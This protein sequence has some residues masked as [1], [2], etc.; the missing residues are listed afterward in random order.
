MRRALHRPLR[1]VVFCLFSFGTGQAQAPPASLPTEVDSAAYATGLETEGRAPSSA[2]APGGDHVGFALGF[3]GDVD[4]DGT[5]DLLIG[6]Y[7][8]DSVAGDAG[9]LFVIAGGRGD[10]L[11]AL[12]GRN[13]RDNFGAAIAPTGDVD[14]DGHPDFAVG[15][16]GVDGMSPDERDK[17]C[18]YFCSGQDGRVIDSV[19]GTGPGSRLGYVLANAGDL[20]GDGVPD[21]AVAQRR[22]GDSAHGGVATV[23]VLAGGTRAR[24][25]ELV[26][27]GAHDAFGSAIAGGGDID[28]DGRPD[29]I[30]GAYR[31]SPTLLSAGAVFIYSGADGELTARVD[32]R[33]LLAHFGYSVAGL[34]D[35]DGDRRGEYV[36]GSRF[37]DEEGG[38]AGSVIILSGPTGRVLR[39]QA[40]RSGSLFGSSVAALGDLDLDRRYELAVGAPRGGENGGGAVYVFAGSDGK[41]MSTLAGEAA[42][43]HFGIRVA[44]GGDGDG[45]GVPDVLVGAVGNDEGGV[46]AGKVYLFSGRTFSLLQTFAG[47]SRITAQDT[48]RV[49]RVVEAERAIK[50]AADTVTLPE[51]V[52]DSTQVD[53]MPILRRTVNAEYPREA[54]GSG[55]AGWVQVRVL[56]LADGAPGRVDIVD[57][58][59]LGPD[60]RLAAL[61]AARQWFFLPATR[62]G[63]PVPAWAVFPIGFAPEERRE[64]PTAD[65]AAGGEVQPDSAGRTHEARP[66]ASSTAMADA[67]AAGPRADAT[68]P[69]VPGP[70]DTLGAKI[71]PAEAPDSDT[72]SAPVSPLSTVDSTARNTQAED[73]PPAAGDAV[74]GPAA[75]QLEVDPARIYEVS[76]LDS[77]PELAAKVAPQYP[78]AAL[79]AG[80]TGTV[81]VAATVDTL[82]AVIR[83]DAVSCTVPGKGFEESAKAAV[84]R[85]RFGP[86]LRGGRKATF[87]V[88]YPVEFRLQ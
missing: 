39:K 43:D 34:G 84:R 81:V 5:D 22:S 36:V 49:A 11:A 73:V 70:T 28:G 21:L 12:F 79:L 72:N 13:E 9:A 42:G 80:D 50:V 27:P 74:T 46:D 37:D 41:L 33:M 51:V 58:A 76:D 20:D 64:G 85:W 82:G 16:P 83:A 68:V 8:N 55:L 7:G 40:G 66:S 87:R 54:L 71:E 23:V 69:A 44:G 60:F 78:A 29:L 19:L 61:T 17:G 77:E 26:A 6:A 86:G 1:L 88:E 63:Q 48:A 59:G 47:T 52:Y 30:A 53:V 10:T 2:V 14:G 35:L 25:Y 75:R 24:L 15:A 4:G 38:M 32:G 56:V 67:A 31:F 18:V 57:D 45:D 62:D 65:S 3:A